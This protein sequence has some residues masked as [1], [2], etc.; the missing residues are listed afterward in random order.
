MSQMFKRAAVSARVSA[1]ARI[2]AA[3]AFAIATT[4]ATAATND[5]QTLSPRTPN[6]RTLAEQSD[7]ARTGRYDEVVRLCN[8]YQEA[9][10]KQVR[11]FDFGRTPEGR[12]MVALVASAD[13][14]LSADAAHAKARPVVLMQGGIHAGEIDGKD[15]GFWALR[16]VLENRAAKGALKDAVFVFVPVFNV[17]GHERFGQ[18]NRPNQV[19]PEEMGWRTTGQNFNLNRDYVKADAPEMQAMLRLLNEWDPILYVDL[20]VTD[21][22]DFEHDISIVVEPTLSDDQELR[23]YAVEMRETALGTLRK[24]GSLPLGFYP[25]LIRNDDPTSGFADN[26]Y[27]PRFSHRYWALRNRIGVL[28]ETHSWKNYKT[29]VRA[30]YHTIISLLEQTATTGRQWLAAAQVAEQRATKLG[31]TSIPLAYRNTDRSR[32]IDFRGY[33]YTRTR[34]TI[35]GALMTKYDSSKPQIWRVPLFYEVEPATVAIAPLGGYVVAPAY[36]DFVAE[37][38]KL[39]GIRFILTASELKQ[40]ELETFR[41]NRATISSTTNEGHATLSVDGE[42]RGENRDVPSG[43]LFVP[44]GQPNA[45]IAMTL[46]EPNSADS[47]LAWG[48]FNNAFERKEYMEAYV[49]EQVAGE[50]LARDPAVKAEFERLLREDESFAQSPRA[51]LE[52]F[53]RRHASW[54]ERYNL[55]PV[56]RSQK[57]LT[58]N[59]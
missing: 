37:K 56:Y 28:V 3:I 23:R 54:D 7:F 29:R 10:P 4:S 13:G 22:A 14:V 11:C 59:P 6:L 42:W 41:A 35:S 52:F 24:Q 40:R 8:A 57:S 21:G 30:T 34:S 53:Y 27:P 16:D 25:T 31:G 19:G 17:D 5:P 45:V 36:A 49:A 44:I 58:F 39:H 38:L 46:F 12:S 1:M 48:F 33:S 18:W 55:Y 51:R 9:W 32:T 43:S 50:M 2:S 47:L 26:V 15:A 20:H